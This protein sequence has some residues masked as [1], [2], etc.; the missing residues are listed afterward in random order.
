MKIDDLIAWFVYY[1]EM[2]LLLSKYQLN[3]ADETESQ[4]PV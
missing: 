2:L 4:F 1:F 3:N